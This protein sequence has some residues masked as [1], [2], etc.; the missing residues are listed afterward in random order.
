MSDVRLSSVI[1]VDRRGWVLL[2][3]RD[4]HPVLDPEKWGFCGGHLEDGE[5]FEAGA[6]RELAEETGIVLPPG[7]LRFWREYRL[8]RD[9]HGEEIPLQLWLAAT[10]LT[11]GEVGCHEGR[12]IVFV[13]PAEALR[14]DLGAAPAVVLP[15]LLGSDDYQRLLP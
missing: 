2:Q 9:E 14:L 12:R 3:E 13:E 10:D 15:D 7:T 11:D 5:D 1:L 4:E 6:Y 8:L